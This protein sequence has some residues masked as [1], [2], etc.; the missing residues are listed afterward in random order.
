MLQAPA[1]LSAPVCKSK[2][3]TKKTY[4]PRVTEAQDEYEETSSE[5]AES[6]SFLDDWDDWF[7]V[8]S[9]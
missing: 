3:K 5:E 4:K 7:S 1:P 9:D 8:D 2:S 6:T